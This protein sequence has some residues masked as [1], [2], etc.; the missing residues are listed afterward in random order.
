MRIAAGS[1]V[2]VIMQRVDREA[3]YQ[4]TYYGAIVYPEE[5]YLKAL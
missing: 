5:A 2:I 1:N 3:S 4:V